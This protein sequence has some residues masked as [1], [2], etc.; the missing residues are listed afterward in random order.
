MTTNK[1]LFRWIYFLEK[2][3]RLS[4]EYM[5]VETKKPRKIGAFS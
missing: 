2:Y 5:R 3:Y 4:P 1:I